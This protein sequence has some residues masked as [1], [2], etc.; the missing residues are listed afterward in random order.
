M[1]LSIKSSKPLQNFYLEDLQNQ[2]HYIMLDTNVELLDGWYE[3]NVCYVDTNIEIF[4]I[5][6]NDVSIKHLLHTGY[7]IDGQGK[8]S[9]PASAVWT[10]NGCFKIWIHTE[11]GMLIQRLY[12]SIRNGDYG[13]NLFENYVLTVDRP[14]QINDMFD[15]DIKS[16]FA[17]ADGPNWW[18]KNTD[19]TPWL[20][21]SLENINKENLLQEFRKILPYTVHKKDGRV[22]LCIREDFKPP[23]LPFIEID[24]I[25]SEMV[26]NLLRQIGYKRI[27][28]IG[29]NIQKPRQSL[30]IH[31][32]D[33]YESDAYPYIKGCKKFFWTLDNHENVY[34]KL[35][36]SGLLPHEKPILINT[37]A[38][39]HS[40][41]NQSDKERSSLSI[42]GEM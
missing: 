29:I 30:T 17:Q 12:E 2:K 10:K 41:V 27:I 23:R 3:L 38:H 37:V 22:R 8:I 14:I 18:L 25:K 42:I 24:T 6:I 33:H 1:K 19:T 36:K 11:I 20:P 28:D 40:I 32:D 21:V 39:T 16:F 4:D 9:Q 31:I 7:H 26:Q 35:G 15:N 34:Y 5:L 13:K